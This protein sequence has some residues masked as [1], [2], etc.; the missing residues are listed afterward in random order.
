MKKLLFLITLAIG[1]MACESIEEKPTAYQC[2]IYDESGKFYTQVDVF[3]DEQQYW[4]S[5]EKFSKGYKLPEL[6]KHGE[7]F[8]IGLKYGQ[9]PKYFIEIKNIT[10][11]IKV[12]LEDFSITGHRIRIETQG[13]WE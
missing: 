5:G 7:G 9:Y 4:M 11:N 6:I 12:Y 2:W 8:T 13:D 3:I 1:L 10:D